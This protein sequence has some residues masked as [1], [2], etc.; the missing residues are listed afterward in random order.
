MVVRRWVVCA[1][2]VRMN[3]RWVCI[4]AGRL[5]AGCVASAAVQAC[6]RQEQKHTQQ[7]HCAIR[8]GMAEL[9]G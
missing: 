3:E 2:R 4:R 6:K 1:V 8:R 7:V 9:T 5:A